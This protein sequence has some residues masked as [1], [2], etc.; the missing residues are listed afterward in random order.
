[1]VLYA[2]NMGEKQGLEVILDAAA[3]TRYNQDIR[4][5]FVGEGAARKR[6]MDRAQRLGLETVSFFSLYNQ[7]TDSL[8]C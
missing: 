4:Y 5:V 7:K 6:L 3:I 8:C 1:M 2:G